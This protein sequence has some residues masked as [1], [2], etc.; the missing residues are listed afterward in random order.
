LL[1]RQNEHTKQLSCFVCLLQSVQA[2]R[3]E[4]EVAGSGVDVSVLNRMYDVEELSLV[5]TVPNVS[6]L[7]HEE[8]TKVYDSYSFAHRPQNLPIMAYKQKVS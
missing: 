3:S 1:Q 7:P 8:L 4:Q 2:H 6:D 5:G